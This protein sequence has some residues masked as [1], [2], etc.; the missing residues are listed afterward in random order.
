MQMCIKRRYAEIR[1]CFLFAKF[2]FFIQYRTNLKPDSLPEYFLKT[3]KLGLNIYL[4]SNRI[5]ADNLKHRSQ[6]ILSS[7][8]PKEAL[9]IPGE[10]CKPNRARYQG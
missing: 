4:Y 7:P 8:I 1:I 5:G 2:S 9:S 6:A 3:V 10:A